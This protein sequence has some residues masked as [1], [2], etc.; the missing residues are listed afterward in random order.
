M[1][2][3]IFIILIVFLLLLVACQPTPETPIVIGKDQDIMIGKAGEEAVYVSGTPDP[4]EQRVDWAERLGT[5]EHCAVTLTSGSGHLHVE[6]NADVYL[7]DAEL[8]IA[9]VEPRRFTDEDAQRFV[10]A[11]LGEDP[12]CVDPDGGG[13]RT[14]AM[15]EEDIRRRMDALDNWEDYGSDVYDSYE[16]KAEFQAA[17]QKL[18]DEA[19]NAPDTLDTFAPTYEWESM[20]AGKETGGAEMQDQVMNI[21]TLNEDATRSSM[22]ITRSTVGDSYLRYT[23]NAEEPVSYPFDCSQYPNELNTSEEQAIAIAAETLKNMGLTHLRYAFSKSIRNYIGDVQRE[24]NP[25]RPYWAVVFTPEV[26]GAQMTYTFQR[27]MEVSEYNRWWDEECCF[28]MVDDS[29]IAAVEYSSPCSVTEITVPNATLMSFDQI[30]AILPAGGFEYELKQCR[31][32]CKFRHRERIE[33]AGECSS[34]D[35]QERGGGVKRGER[36]A[37]EDHSDED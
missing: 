9:R 32:L 16:T 27:S 12:Q 20:Y 33:Q 15:Y 19:K 5:P 28:V 29:G 24:K 26:N 13:T 35:D 25:Y 21:L 17:L 3:R 23:R 36:R 11:L 34:N 10:T 22:W 8:P 30:R 4:D 7:P 2:K 37:L 18:M 14:K 31:S 1:K 6:V